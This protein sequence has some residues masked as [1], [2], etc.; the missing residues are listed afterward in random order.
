MRYL[1][2][3]MLCATWL[4]ALP[5]HADD[6]EIIVTATR[7]PSEADRLPA[8]VD[9]IDVDKARS[10]GVASFADVLAESPGLHVVQAGGFGQQ[11]SLFSG[12]ANSNHTLVLFDGIRLND[13]S[14]P[15]SAFD[16][17][18][19]TLGGLTRIEVVQGP[20]SA[21]YG[22]DAIGGV[23][24]LLPRHGRNGALNAQ[25]DISSGSFD[26]LMA[27]TA[28]DGTLGALR[29]AVT[30]EGFV[31]D[32]YDIVPKRMSTHTGD[33]D[34]AESASFTGVFDLDLSEALSLDLLV[35]QRRAQAEFDAFQ[36]TMAFEEYRADDPDLEIAQNDLIV[37][38][39]GATWRIAD[40]LSLRA[41]QGELNYERRERDDGATTAR[42]EGRRR[43][44]DFTAEWRPVALFGFSSV[45]VLAGA[46]T[47]TE[48]V[49]IVTPFTAIGAEQNRAGG[50]ITAQGDIHALTLT[51]AARLD[52]FDGFGAQDTWR[53]GASYAIGDVA[54]VYANVG[55]S[56][57]AP[58]LNERFDPTY[59][60]ASLEAEDATG[61]EAGVD[62]WFEAFGQERGLEIGAL[63]RQTDVSNLITYASAF[64]FAFLN[65]DEAELRSAE[66]R[67][68]LRPMPWL[69]A[70][71]G[72]VRTSAEN[73]TT[74]AALARRSEHSWTA[75]LFAQRGAFSAQVSWRRVGEQFDR[76]Y[77]DDGFFIGAG[78]LPAYDV[79]DASAAW[80]VADGAQ[81]YV[82]GRN[83]TDETYETPGA[84]AGAPRSVMLG[85]RL[86]ASSD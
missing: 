29:Y 80:D 55:T 78:D 40:T 83:L 46:E 71:F 5:A 49:D 50:F 39:V 7:H 47:E 31:T 16:A 60:N 17:G 86:S 84:F 30:G 28:L 69:S 62:A 53:I 82:A 38:R 45:G 2:T 81:V 21:V 74:G 61:W 32:G 67:L 54:R 18:Q 42:F 3:A 63:H 73:T 59:G 48:R 14:S 27:T 35:R 70:N 26:T 1:I 68:T 72:Y 36:Y 10:R 75:S 41:S 25:L 12:G 37:A 13:P 11:T 34:G 56:F 66:A 64:P 58:T 22:S 76:L 9:V 23:V 8:D 52:D 57:R 24:N 15:N 20:M 4:Y 6:T 33:A 65:I 51:A 79:W 85:L 44:G 19:D 77:G 43:F